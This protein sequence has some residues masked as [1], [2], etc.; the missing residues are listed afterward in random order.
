MTSPSP[1][2]LVDRYLQ[3]CEDRDLAAASAFLAPGA[4]LN[5]PGGRSHPSLAAMAAAASGAYRWVRKRRDRYFEA[6]GDGADQVVISLGTLYGEDLAGEPF[7]GVRYAD[8]FVL[9]DGLIVEQNVF[10]DLPEAGIV[11]VPTPR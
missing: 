3:L 7:S 8:V 1:A 11:P 2:A 6:A 10:N 9:R 5:F 4:R